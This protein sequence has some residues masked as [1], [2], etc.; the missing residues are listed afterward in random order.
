MGFEVDDCY[1]PN[2]TPKLTLSKLPFW[3][4]REPPP[5][6]QT[7]PLR[8]S[9]SVP[10]QWEEV[11][12][13]PRAAVGTA[14]ETSPSSTTPPS[15]K[16][17]TAA[18]CLD[19]P[20]RLLHDESKITIMPSPTTVLGGP[21]VGRSL[22]LACTFSFRKGLV[23][24]REEGLRPAKRSSKRNFGS[25]RWGSFKDEE[26]FSKGKLDF[27]RSLGDIFESDR[28]TRVGR[29]RSFFSINSNLWVSFF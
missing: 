27:S 26:K 9:V 6:M 29:K 24:G 21:Y 25:G 23:S 20:P 28:I 16:N 19:L 15:S 11:P 7:P 14:V 13:K 22:S 5:L 18:R 4:P 12:G 17:K 8:P 1:E 3:K 2:S 10:F